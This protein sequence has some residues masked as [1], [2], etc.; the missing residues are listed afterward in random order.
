MRQYSLNE[1]E[2][3]RIAKN[4]VANKIKNQYRLVKSQNKKMPRE[5]IEIIQE[6]EKAKRMDTLRGIEGNVSK[7]FFSI[8]FKDINWFA[9]MPRVKPDVPNFLLDM[10][11]NMLFNFIDALLNLFG[12]DTYKGCYHKLFFPKKITFL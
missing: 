2:E 4:I 10:G 6:I 3:M 9:R 1:A 12:F 7:D 5:E 8:Y 11:Y